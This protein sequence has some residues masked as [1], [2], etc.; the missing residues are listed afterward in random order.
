MGAAVSSNTAKMAVGIYNKMLSTVNVTNTNATN[1]TQTD[2]LSTCD[3]FTEGGTVNL[4]QNSSQALQIQ[5][6]T[7]NRNQQQA[8]NTVNQQLLQQAQ[9]TISNYGIGVAA[10][11]NN[12]S[13]AT[14]ISTA[15]DSA[16]NT[17]N[18][19]VANSLQSLVCTDGSVIDTGGGDF[20]AVQTSGQ[21]ITTTQT[22]T[23][24]NWQD[25]VNSVTQSA[26]QTASATVTGF[27]IGG[28]LL[29]VLGVV[30]VLVLVSAFAKMGKDKDKTETK[31]EGGGKPTLLAGLT[32]GTWI[33][34]VV[35]MVC[36]V[37]LG[38]VGLQKR[39]EYRCNYDAQCNYYNPFA[40]DILTTDKTCSCSDHLACGLRPDWK[41]SAVTA[42]P[43]FMANPVQSNVEF[44]GRSSNDALLSPGALQD[45]ALL[46]ASGL[47]ITN[48]PSGNNSGYNVGV[49]NTLLNVLKPGTKD[50]NA[51][52]KA[53]FANALA[54]YM[55]RQMYSPEENM[56]AVTRIVA[57][58]GLPV[59]PDNWCM[60]RL[61]VNFIPIQPFFA[62]P[63]KSAADG[64]TDTGSL[65]NFKNCTQ[66]VPQ[67]L[68]NSQP[69]RLLQQRLQ[70]M[71]TP[72]SSPQPSSSF[73]RAA[74]ALGVED[75][76]RKLVGGDIVREVAATARK[77]QAQALDPVTV[78]GNWV[79]TDSPSGINI[80]GN[81]C[82]KTDGD[83]FRFKPVA[84]RDTCDTGYTRMWSA[85]PPVLLA[86]NN[87]TSCNIAYKEAL[88]TGV[89]QMA[90]AD[91]QC[92]VSNLTV[93]DNDPNINLVPA[94]YSVD[95]EC[96]LTSTTCG[97]SGKL[98]IPDRLK[99][100]E[101]QFDTMDN[102]LAG[103][104]AVASA[105]AISQ[106]TPPGYYY[107]T[108]NNYVASMGIINSD[109]EDVFAADLS[110][111]FIK[112]SD[113]SATGPPY[114]DADQCNKVAGSDTESCPWNVDACAKLSGDT[115]VDGDDAQGD[116]GADGDSWSPPSG[117]AYNTSV[118]YDT[119]GT[120]VDPA[121]AG[122][123]NYNPYCNMI[124][125]ICTSNPSLP[126]YDPNCRGELY[127][128]YISKGTDNHEAYY[129]RCYQQPIQACT[130][131]T[132]S[133]ETPLVA[134]HVCSLTNHAACWNRSLCSAV[135]ASWTPMFNS[136]GTAD[137]FV[138]T[139]TPSCPSAVTSASTEASCSACT[140][141]TSCLAS[142]AM[143]ITKTA[144]C[145]CCYE[146][147]TA[148]TCTTTKCLR[149]DDHTP[150]PC[151]W[152]PVPQRPT[153][154]AP[155]ACTEGCGLTI[156]SG[157]GWD[158]QRNQ[159]ILACNPQANVCDNCAGPSCGP[160]CYWGT[161]EDAGCSVKTTSA[162]CAGAADPGC[163][164]NDDAACVSSKGRCVLGADLCASA[165]DSNTAAACT[166]G[167][168]SRP[169]GTI[170]RRPAGTTR[171]SGRARQTSRGGSGISSSAARLTHLTTGMRSDESATSTASAST[172]ASTHAQSVAGAAYL[173]AAN[174][175]MRH[176]Y[177]VRMPSG[178][179]N[180][181]STS[182]STDPN[183]PAGCLP[184]V[185]YPLVSSDSA[186]PLFNNTATSLPNP[187]SK[188]PSRTC[189]NVST[190]QPFTGAGTSD[191]S[192]YA[193][194]CVT[195][196]GTNPQIELTAYTCGCPADVCTGDTGAATTNDYVC[197]VNPVVASGQ[198]TGGFMLRQA[199]M[200]GGV[201]MGKRGIYDVGDNDS[202]IDEEMYFYVALPSENIVLW[203]QTNT[204]DSQVK[205]L[206]M[207]LRIY[208]WILL[209]VD[210]SSQGMSQLGLSTF[211]NDAGW[212]K[213][214]NS[215]T[216][217]L[218]SGLG[219]L[220]QTSFY[221]TQPLLVYEKN[222]TD[223]KYDS[224]AFYTMQ[225]L[226]EGVYSQSNTSAGYVT[227]ATP[228]LLPDAQAYIAQLSMWSYNNGDN[229]LS[230]NVA[231][232]GMTMVAMAGPNDPA[233]Q[234]SEG[235][236][237]QGLLQGTFGY[238]NLW[239]TGDAFVGGT[240]GTACGMLALAIIYC[241]VRKRLT[242]K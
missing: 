43:L 152:G 34:Y 213:K 90:G 225:E 82:Y 62:A 95:G 163:F 117:A 113:Y 28:I 103:E 223:G 224:P 139:K 168:R 71:D 200:F 29:A 52:S 67:Q 23:T 190:Y 55:Y 41:D 194:T 59:E 134:S 38:A 78:Y 141:K 76:V 104:Y 11:I 176:L 140:D 231:R 31:L 66:A 138:C 207:F 46:Q 146:Q 177:C 187:S 219:E 174:S 164:W 86:T 143:P 64:T 166:S 100:L 97:A 150:C 183:A 87:D 203:E 193:T 68:P 178:F 81:V 236:K 69:A 61:L 108:I 241:V 91:S 232:D 161:D 151:S 84:L 24:S 121:E 158:D 189:Y 240:L 238:C 199:S 127:A 37:V 211:L 147:Q 79:Q 99:E 186:I 44:G 182:I 210:A 13:M 65:S 205:R 48:S 1:N 112:P 128:N 39:S 110:G 9:S 7:T 17:S 54:A 191:A 2:I 167:A 120:G 32:L 237:M 56:D 22:T 25:I 18:T 222:S 169:A 98:G 88:A 101:C 75:A 124:A 239:F 47:G 77:A 27:S 160:P 233:G 72:S 10:A 175:N 221:S 130:L 144:E 154:N 111:L 80:F 157:C 136:G 180:F 214:S 12:M 212:D 142:R 131:Y 215:P 198:T 19:N 3:I 60:T 185:F 217:T 50:T 15:V 170:G 206:F 227:S 70:P 8:T 235:Q 218:D 21:D 123:G 126:D 45:M 116:I 40:S 5:Q 83:L 133:K 115:G 230:G 36:L 105:M 74:T 197:W 159:C 107:G 129:N 63:L 92:F 165:D 173:G 135:G 202:E 94:S 153:T 33:F 155:F 188:T 137:G 30:L 234:L 156:N 181:S 208:Y 216:V 179:A 58:D 96:H 242:K 209:T 73:A 14:N 85:I 6:Y 53:K 42:P 119:A 16:I 109:M 57:P 114:K 51:T 148:A 93:A 35:V 102:D 125:G 122:I 201:G 229:G 171:P 228:T 26:Q 184:N 118:G 20:I 162:S 196:V 145:S 172:R 149:Q 195:A 106:V 204:A 132:N 226:R 4:S 49:F 220:R 192:V 89:S